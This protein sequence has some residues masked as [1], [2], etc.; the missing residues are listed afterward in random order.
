VRSHTLAARIPTPES[1]TE[2]QYTWAARVE[3]K[4]VFF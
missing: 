1:E 3:K 4:K 2:V